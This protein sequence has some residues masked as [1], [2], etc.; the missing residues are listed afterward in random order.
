MS[1]GMATLA[2]DE[3][4]LRIGLAHDTLAALRANIGLAS[5]FGH[6]LQS[7]SSNRE[8]ATNTKALALIERVEALIQRHFHEYEQCWKALQG[9]GGLDRHEH[10][11]LQ[12][13]IQADLESLNN[14]LVAE[15]YKD[16]ST[17]LPW[18]WKVSGQGGGTSE[19]DGMANAVQAWTEEGTRYFSAAEFMMFVH[20][21]LIVSTVLRLEY[22]HARSSYEQWIE[23]YHI[24]REEQRRLPMAFEW[25]AK[26]FE[27]LRLGSSVNVWEGADEGGFQAWCW[28]QEQVWRQHA[29][30][31][32]QVYH[33]TTS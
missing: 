32:L 8:G 33:E 19:S 4:M 31:A 24:L 21:Q 30:R 22:V 18:I 23:E 15:K 29:A 20:G 6:K 10:G 2:H 14:W 11:G 28:Q 1:L 27:Q 16:S 17:H 13:L 12:P 7:K 3:Q 26:R 5:F 9:L 25:E